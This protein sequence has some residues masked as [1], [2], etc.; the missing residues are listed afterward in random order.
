MRGDMKTVVFLDVKKSVI[1]T[2]DR[3]VGIGW[4][5]GASQTPC[6]FYECLDLWGIIF[7][8]SISKGR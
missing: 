8:W 3:F 7:G 2:D 4:E 6:S 5:K 1:L